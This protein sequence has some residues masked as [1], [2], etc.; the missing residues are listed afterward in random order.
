M[1]V[2]LTCCIHTYDSI[3]LTQF[4]IICQVL[5]RPLE[6]SNISCE[7]EIVDMKAFLSQMLEKDSVKLCIVGQNMHT[8][9]HAV[10]CQEAVAKLVPGLVFCHCQSFVPHAELQKNLRDRRNRS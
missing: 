10:E 1:K 9:R 7:W 4:K 6:A 8:R 5:N 3:T 2:Y